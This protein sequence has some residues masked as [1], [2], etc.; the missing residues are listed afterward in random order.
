MGI[1]HH[2][3]NLSPMFAY[4]SSVVVVNDKR[5]WEFRYKMQYEEPRGKWYSNIIDSLLEI[6][7]G[8]IVDL[9]IIS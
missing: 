2:R 4:D 9:Q 6:K 1:G 5:G 7:K 3:R 8:R